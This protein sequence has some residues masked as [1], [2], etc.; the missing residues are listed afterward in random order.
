L[1]S[2]S[3]QKIRR[4]RKGLRDGMR[5]G[6]RG[7]GS[8][9]CDDGTRCEKYPPLVLF[10]CN[11]WAQEAHTPPACGISTDDRTDDS[12]HRKGGGVEERWRGVNERMHACMHPRMN[13][14]SIHAQFPC[15]LV[16]AAI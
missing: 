12:G 15:T 9:D 1:S 7:R 3:F 2:S 10:S 8:D 16:R 5:R 4:R 14:R 13:A 6:R 11:R